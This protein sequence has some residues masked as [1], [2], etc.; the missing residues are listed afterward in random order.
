MKCYIIQRLV[1]SRLR[2]STHLFK[3]LLCAVP[4]CLLTKESLSILTISCHVCLHKM[5]WL[6][7]LNGLEGPL[8]QPSGQ[9]VGFEH[10][11]RGGKET[12]PSTR[13]L[14]FSI[15]VNIYLKPCIH[16]KSENVNIENEAIAG[17]LG[18]W[19]ETELTSP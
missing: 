5:L 17:K 8:S 2:V 14:R 19:A 4:H 18:K 13:K 15:K 10:P 12:C 3:T 11:L 1:S 16:L 9:L 7:Q 6:Y